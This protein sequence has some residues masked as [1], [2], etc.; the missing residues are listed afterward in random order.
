[1]TV[2]YAL[3][4]LLKRLRVSINSVLASFS[5]TFFSLTNA[6]ATFL[7]LPPRPAPLTYAAPTGT[8]RLRHTGGDQVSDTGALLQESLLLDII[9]EL[10][11]E[12]LHLNQTDSHDSGCLLAYALRLIC[13]L[14][15]GVVSVVQAIDES[16]GNSDNVLQRSTQGNTGNLAIS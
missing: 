7:F 5:L 16:G 2:Q 15:L 12:V 8:T 13:E 3:L 10:L 6:S 1:L 11:A 4:E 9:E 14:T